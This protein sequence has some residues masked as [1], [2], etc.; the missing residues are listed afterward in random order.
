MRAA[1]R[2]RLPDAYGSLQCCA[3]LCLAAC[4]SETERLISVRIIMEL[5][6]EEQLD[7]YEAFRR[8]AI[9]KLKI[10]RVRMH[11]W[12]EKA[13]KAPVNTWLCRFFRQSQVTMCLY[14]C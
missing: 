2:L 9:D 13:G 5:M 4:L 12:V 3:I 11:F 10:K 7:R 8:C 1:P 6:T 14:Q